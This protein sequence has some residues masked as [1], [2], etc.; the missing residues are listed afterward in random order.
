MCV[1]ITAQLTPY[2]WG[3]KTLQVFF[4]LAVFTA[5]TLNNSRHNARWA[6]VMLMI[7]M[8]VG[9][10]WDHA[11]CLVMFKVTQWDVDTVCALGAVHPLNVKVYS[12]PRRRPRTM[13]L[14]IKLS[15][16]A[17]VRVWPHHAGLGGSRSECLLCGWYTTCVYVF[18][19]KL[20][21]SSSTT[22]VCPCRLKRKT[23]RSRFVCLFVCD[24]SVRPWSSSD[25]LSFLWSLKLLPL[26]N[27][28]VVWRGLLW[29]KEIQINAVNVFFFI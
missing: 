27:R 26:M 2:L 6:Y 22:H 7:Q 24:P 15:K 14:N 16:T 12:T 11:A 3:L 29:T 9:S 10:S 17:P 20:L 8:P 25:L 28:I 23:R 19:S 21:W 13:Q 1:S 4:L 5:Q 18:T